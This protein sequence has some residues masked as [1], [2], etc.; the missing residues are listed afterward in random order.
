MIDGDEAVA[1]KQREDHQAADLDV[2]GVGGDS[3]EQRAHV[4]HPSVVH[5]PEPPG[6]E[7]VMPG[8]LADRELYPRQAGDLGGGGNAYRGARRAPPA[9]R[10]RRQSP[11]SRDDVSRG[12]DRLRAPFAAA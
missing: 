6:N 1:D 8:P 12:R 9:E 10:K 2:V 5:P 11:L 7:L 4:V 3:A